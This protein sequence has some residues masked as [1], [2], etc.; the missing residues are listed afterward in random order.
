[1]KTVLIASKLGFFRIAVND[2]RAPLTAANFL[3]YV[4]AG[5]YTGGSFY[6]TVRQ[7][8]QLSGP[9]IDVVQGGLGLE[10]FDESYQPPFKPIPH[11]STN[12]TG[13]LHLDGTISMSRMSVG[14]ASSEFFICVGRQP[15]LDWGGRRN[16]D[17]LG[18]AA[19]GKI[20]EGMD[21]IRRIQSSP[22]NNS[23]P[24]GWPS[25]QG[26]LL[27]CPVLRES[28]VVVKQPR[29]ETE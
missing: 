15:E 16:P 25:L 17:G 26:Q 20:V 14:T 12:E 7:D 28:A 22:T 2:E 24:E 10:V 27:V 11:E 18:F 3:R 6:R 29:R 5:I 9:Y 21:L 19:F 8:N 1:M 23:A 13:I 4:E